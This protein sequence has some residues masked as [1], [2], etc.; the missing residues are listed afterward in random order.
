MTDRISEHF[1][2]EEAT[3]T[4]HTDLEAINRIQGV[5]YLK[6]INALA[7]VI[8]EPIRAKYGAFGISSWFRGPELNKAVG[9]VETSQHCRGEAAD[10]CRSDWTWEELDNV[11]NWIAK[12]SCIVF[13]QIIRERQGDKVWLHCSSGD[14]CETLD[15]DNK[16]YIVRT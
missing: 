5:V 9:G 6:E 11:A 14:R 12:K 2:F 15:H 7:T 16:G 4:R 13:G 1:T 3:R 10:L 8:L